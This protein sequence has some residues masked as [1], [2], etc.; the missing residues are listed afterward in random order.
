MSLFLATLIPALLLLVAGALLLWNAPVVGATAR[1]FPR[2]RRAA[3]VLFGAGAAWFLYIVTHLTEA[4]FG[5]YRL[6]L[7]IVFAGIAILSFKHVPDFLA[8]RGLAVLVLLGA[9]HFLTAAFMKWE[10]SQRLFMVSLVYAAII[11]SLFLAGYP[12]RMRDFLE[13][14]FAR[15][16]RAR[17]AGV[18]CGGYGLLLAIVS[19]TY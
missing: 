18:L 9:G 17:T 19:F 6:V 3:W 12:Y 13:W 1:A 8:V 4:D 16:T 2:S 11:A 7:F 5:N 10:F 15:P 14:L